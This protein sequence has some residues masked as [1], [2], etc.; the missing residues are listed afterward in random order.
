MSTS[1]NERHGKTAM[2]KKIAQHH[3]G[4]VPASILNKAGGL[5]NFVFEITVSRKKY[6][7][8]IGDTADKIHDFQ[9]EQWAIR[10][11][12]EIG[13]PVADILEVGNNIIDLPYMIQT[14]VK[15]IDGRHHPNADTTVFEL[16]KY[17]ALIH[18]IRTKGYGTVFDW[19][20]NKLSKKSSWNSFLEDEFALDERM[21]FLKRHKLV[22][23]YT[24]KKLN[25][26]AKEINK[27]DRAPRLNHGDLRLKNV[28]TNDK[29]HIAAILDWENC[30]SNMAP[31]WDMSIALHDLTIDEKQ[32]FLNGYGI[33]EKK[34]R[35]IAGAIK[36]F[37]LLNYTTHIQLMIKDNDVNMLRQYRMRLN[38]YYD[39]YSL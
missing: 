14:Y 3:F 12:H 26:L 25:A 31:E 30:S 37:N 34:F 17:A 15:G 38:G 6:I 11:A 36:F 23:P 2:V 8:R 1:K 5:T 10:R 4:S 13:V 32:L 7:I 9:K 33:K 19:S 35:D 18:S 22:S 16:G 28:I 20:D 27:W 24:V 29:G 21:A 39:L